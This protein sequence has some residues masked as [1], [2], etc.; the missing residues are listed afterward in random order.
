MVEKPEFEMYELYALML[1]NY[2]E[3]YKDLQQQYEFCK[4]LHCKLKLITFGLEIVSLNSFVEQLESQIT[5]K[6]S[7]ILKEMNIG[8]ISNDDN[9]QADGR[10]NAN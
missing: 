3:V 8:F 1:A 7:D 10:G 5:P 6:I 9:E 4:C 2:K